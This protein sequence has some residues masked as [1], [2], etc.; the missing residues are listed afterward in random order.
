LWDLFWFFLAKYC[1]LFCRFMEA[2]ALVV[3]RLRG[4]RGSEPGGEHPYREVSAI[5]RLAA[6]L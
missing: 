2:V 3:L 5:Q 1:R 4:G 6:A